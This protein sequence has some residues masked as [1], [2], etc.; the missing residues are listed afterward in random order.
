MGPL[1]VCNVDVAC[2]LAADDGSD[3]AHQSLGI[4]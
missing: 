3:V 4:A 2:D 1:L